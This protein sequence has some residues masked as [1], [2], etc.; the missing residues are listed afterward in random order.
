MRCHVYCGFFFALCLLP[1]AWTKPLP[2]NFYDIFGLPRGRPFDPR[3]LKK[4]YREL[5]KKYH[6]DLNKTDPEAEGNF[7]KV[8]HGTSS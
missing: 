1:G 4:A 8:A 7:M 3:D 5:S 2:S 6:P